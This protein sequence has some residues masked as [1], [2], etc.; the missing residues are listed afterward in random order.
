[1][2]IHLSNTDLHSRKTTDDLKDCQYLSMVQGAVC[3]WHI[4]ESRSPCQQKQQQHPHSTD[5]SWKHNLTEY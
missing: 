5:L 2:T 3:C 4:H 1:M